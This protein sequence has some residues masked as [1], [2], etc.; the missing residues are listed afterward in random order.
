M[1]S[2]RPAAG[3]A[4]VH[5]ARKLTQSPLAS[6]PAGG[7]S[8]LHWAAHHGMARVLRKL[9]EGG[10]DGSGAGGG[11]R[12]GTGTDAEDPEGWVE[13][14]RESM[15]G[16]GLKP[17]TLHMFQ[18]LQCVLCAQDRLSTC[19]Y[20]SCLGVCCRETLLLLLALHHF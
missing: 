5:W 1:L 15:V 11:G 17:A 14:V 10:S 7:R 18:C 8:A 3:R 16:G 12:D 6:R 2:W 4:A 13:R 20:P 19:P 9:L